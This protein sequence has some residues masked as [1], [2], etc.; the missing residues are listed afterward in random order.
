M[1]SVAAGAVELLAAV[2]GSETVRT[3]ARELVDKV[4]AF[5]RRLRRSEAS[6]AEPPAP[7]EQQ[8]PERPPALLL[9][10]TVAVID[11]ARCTRCEQCIGI[12]PM[13]AI[14]LGETVTIDASKCTG[15]GACT[16]ECPTDAISLTELTQGPAS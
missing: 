3:H 16:S 7:A 14:S 8:L 6:G 5:A 1:G 12:C 13:Q 11:E 15:C 4:G 2:L 9:P 10:R